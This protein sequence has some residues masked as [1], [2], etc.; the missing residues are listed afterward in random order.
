MES[1]SELLRT[2]TFP[3]I[4]IFAQ[5]NNTLIP[6]IFLFILLSKTNVDKPKQLL[7][8]FESTIYGLGLVTI[9]TQT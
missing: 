8:R 5:F 6:K 2:E 1:K 7:G 3:L 9:G 4:V